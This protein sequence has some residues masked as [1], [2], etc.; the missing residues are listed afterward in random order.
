MA[1]CVVVDVAAADGAIM[2]PLLAV[3][4][5]NDG[6]VGVMT[7]VWADDCVTDDD[8][9]TRPLT[10]DVSDAFDELADCVGLSAA[11]SNIW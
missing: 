3:A 2:L 6:V 1:T 7:T 10:P 9:V 11:D 8:S 5:S 4:M